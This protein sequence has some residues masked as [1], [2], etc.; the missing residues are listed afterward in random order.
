MEG[1]VGCVT[2]RIRDRAQSDGQA[3]RSQI[4]LPSALHP[5]QRPETETPAPVPRALLRAC[6]DRTRPRTLR[7]VY[8]PVIAIGDL[9]VLFA[10]R[11]LRMFAYGLLGVVLVL[12]L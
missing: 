4:K 3:R 2:D 11:L 12:H 8:S 1:A 6:R 10:A 9:R 7:C 5:A